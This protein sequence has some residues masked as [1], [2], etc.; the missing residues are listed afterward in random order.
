[1]HAEHTAGPWKKHDTYIHDGSLAGGLIAQVYDCGAVNKVCA[2]AAEN[3]SIK[4]A[5]ANARL[6]A[7]APDLLAAL[8]TSLKFAEFAEKNWADQSGTAC[9]FRKEM[10]QAIAKARGETA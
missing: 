4:E 5:Q 7:A 2:A 6:I 1:M 8:E 3:I 10:E 9:A